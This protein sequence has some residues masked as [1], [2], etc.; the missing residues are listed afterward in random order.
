MTNSTVIAAV[1]LL[2]MSHSATAE[3]IDCSNS[4]KSKQEISS[5]AIEPG[6]RPDRRMR[7]FVRIDISSSKNSEWDGAEQTVYGH[8]DSV[9]TEGTHAGYSVAT[10]KSGEKVWAKFEG[11]HYVVSR[12]GN[13]WERHTQGVFRFIGGTGKYKTIRG[14]GYYLG[15]ATPAGLTE[16]DICEAEY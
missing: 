11:V 13:A 2:L 10:L 7:Q 14:G 5:R 3:K 4:K 8:S 1:A 9:A 16:D 6:D 15:I 12:D